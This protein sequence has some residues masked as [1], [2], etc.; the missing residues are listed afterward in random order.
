MASR[1]TETVPI[2]GRVDR[3]GRLIAADPPLE[4]LQ[5]EAGSALGRPLALPQLA[6]LA[7]AAASL[8]VPLSRALLAADSRHD[9]DL[10]V[11]A[12]PQ[13]GEVLLTIERWATRPAAPPRLSLVEPLGDEPDLENTRSALEFTTDAAL[14]IVD[15]SPP[16]A[17]LLAREPGDCVG[18]P[19][20][21][22]FRLVEE[23]NGGMPLLA[24]LASRASIEGQRAI[25]RGGSGEELRIDADPLIDEAGHFAGFQGVLT[26]KGDEGAGTD[27]AGTAFE[28]SLDE[29]LRSPL[30]RII[31]AA[32]RIV[33]RT[34]GPLRSDYANYASDIA[35]A[36]RHLLSVIRSMGEGAASLA[37]HVNVGELATEAVGLVQPL[38]ESRQ[39]EIRI[40]PGESSIMAS[41]EARAIVQA[42][43]NILGNA[44]RHSPDRGVI[45]VTF[46]S[47]SDE[48]RVT[49]S[50]QGPGIAADDQQRVFE[51][52]VRV[53]DGPDG[54]G[55]G[56]AISR[57]LARSMGGDIRLESA[58]GEGAR[59]TLILPS[60]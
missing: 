57:R 44:I 53:D 48:C 18:E 15:V 27:A 39:I 60:A 25:G 4:R 34:D 45:A 26:R 54:S 29:A 17:A 35:A 11:R 9:L 32:D 40:V 16:L 23:E 12:E 3:E 2:S 37:Q 52:Y 47:D 10:F 21:A 13:E 55:L 31:T 49:I 1:P 38:A 50:D 22:L 7:R 46:E 51:R 56:L 59:F 8:G 20:T 14:N 30:A 36:G 6:A 41:G 5:I 19:L 33:E 58:S 24:A 43:V 42:L 28:Q